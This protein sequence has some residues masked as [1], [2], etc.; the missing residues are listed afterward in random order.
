[1]VVTF[2]AYE[3]L[4]LNKAEVA[5]LT[6]EQLLD[7][8]N[9]DI[10]NWKAVQQTEDWENWSVLES[11]GEEAKIKPTPMPAIEEENSLNQAK[12]EEESAEAKEKYYFEPI[13]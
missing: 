12:N 11:I 5:G 7:K 3:S 13:D 1:M 10:A 8:I 9:R 2:K 6:E 4:I